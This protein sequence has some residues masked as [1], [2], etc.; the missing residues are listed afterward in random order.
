MPTSL[1]VIP[2]FATMNPGAVLKRP[3]S[4]CTASDIRTERSSACS[5]VSP[6]T[7]SRRRL[8]YT[9]TVIPWRMYA[10]SCLTTELIS[11]SMAASSVTLS[12]SNS[13]RRIPGTSFSAS[14]CAVVFCVWDPTRIRPPDRLRLPMTSSPVRI[15]RSSTAPNSF[16]KPAA[17]RNRNR[18]PRPIAR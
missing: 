9:A 11:S 8:V 5:G 12:E 3:A 17:V 14:S 13:I 15:P 10:S 7:D 18:F 1:E 6:F 4:C 16:K 2:P